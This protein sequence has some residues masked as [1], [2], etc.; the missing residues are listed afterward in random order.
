MRKLIRL[1][2]LLVVIPIV[3]YTQQI[4]GKISNLPGRQ[5]ILSYSNDHFNYKND[6]LNAT[7]DGDFIFKLK[8][9]TPG[10]AS[11]R[12]SNFKLEV[13]IGP[14]SS[15]DLVADGKNVYLSAVYHGNQAFIN[16]FSTFVNNNPNLRNRSFSKAFYLEPKAFLPALDLYFMTRDSLKKEYFKKRDPKDLLL[17]NFLATDSIDMVYSKGKTL[18]IYLKDKEPN[19][20]L[21]EKYIKGLEV[22]K[23][24]EQHLN[25]IKYI[26]FCT[27]IVEYKVALI[28]AGLPPAES[29]MEVDFYRYKFIPQVIAS[30]FSGKMKQIMSRRYV[31]YIYSIYSNNRKRMDFVDTALEQ[32]YGNIT[33]QEYLTES[34]RRMENTNAKI[35]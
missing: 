2:G 15:N 5:L 25:A 16:N 22:Q 30:N 21:Y 18:L 9:T 4:S 33:N 23:S 31:E 10:Y 3:G 20:G 6:T 32:L 28:R 29:K 14:N 27:E 13:Y 1:L 24:D 11:I 34:R 12:G 17:K 19:N 26:E 35:K 8:K 7:V